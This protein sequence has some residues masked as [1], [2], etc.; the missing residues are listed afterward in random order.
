MNLTDPKDK[1]A[2]I[3]EA[4]EIMYGF[5]IYDTQDIQKLYD[6]KKSLKTKIAELEAILLIHIIPIQNMYRLCY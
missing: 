6:V 2:K 1:V 5:K 4:L 3:S